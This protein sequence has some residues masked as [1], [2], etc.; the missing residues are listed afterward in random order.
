MLIVW[1]EG[2]NNLRDRQLPIWRQPS[3]PDRLNC[4]RMWMGARVQSSWLPSRRR[5]GS[6]LLDRTT[7]SS[8]R[9][10]LTVIGECLPGSRALLWPSSS[11]GRTQRRAIGRCALFEQLALRLPLALL[12]RRAQQLA[13]EPK[14]PLGGL[15]L[16]RFGVASRTSSQRAAQ[17]ALRQGFRLQPHAE[18]RIRVDAQIA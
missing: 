12:A 13:W 11:L 14:R 4:P 3:A 8:V 5:R 7:A 15:C 17:F 16:T 1:T 9:Q 2:A 18:K 6:L 10:E